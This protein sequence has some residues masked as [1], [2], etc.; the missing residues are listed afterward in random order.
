MILSFDLFDTL[1][2]RDVPTPH[3]IFDCFLT[4]EQK[5]VRIEAEYIIKRLF[6]QQY[7]IDEILL[8][9]IWKQCLQS[10]A[11]EKKD[12]KLWTSLEQAVELSHVYFNEDF[13][14]I[15]SLPTRKL[16]VTDMYLPYSFFKVV[17]SDIIGIQ[18]GGYNKL[19]IS[20]DLGLAK[21]TGRI[22]KYICDDNSCEA[23][24]IYHIGDNYEIDVCIPK[25]F[26]VKTCH[27]KKGLLPIDAI[28]SVIM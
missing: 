10:D 27:Y 16:F 18:L 23:S 7:D 19:Y 1:I 28:N 6:K 11:F 20:G 8:D 21:H 12:L 22:W 13:K 26:K 25:R 2:Y 3:H 17:F 4:E 15:I 9:E 24:E 14:D 5:R